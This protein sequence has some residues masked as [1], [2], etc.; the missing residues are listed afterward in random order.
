MEIKKQAILS[1]FDENA[2][3]IDMNSLNLNDDAAFEALCETKWKS[4]RGSAKGYSNHLLEP[5]KK[6]Q[7]STLLTVL[8][9]EHENL[10]DI[11]LCMMCHT[12][13]RNMTFLPCGD[14]ISCASCSETVGC[15]PRCWR[16]IEGVVQTF[17]S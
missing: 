3:D 4:I 1:V 5:R 10:Q 16:T 14:F 2:D 15:C 9:K 6:S 7:R 17:L 8:Q 12:E 11:M 13:K